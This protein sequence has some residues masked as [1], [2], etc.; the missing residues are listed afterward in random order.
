M[1]DA[2]RHQK[3]GRV[4]QKIRV[5][6]VTTTNLK[7]GE[8]V[9]PFALRRHLSIALLSLEY[10]LFRGYICDQI[11][12]DCGIQTLINDGVLVF[13]MRVYKLIAPILFTLQ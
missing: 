9:T 11:C 3:F 4:S 2:I 7:V 12:V 13:S 10:Q 1:V 5:L 6:N 8:A